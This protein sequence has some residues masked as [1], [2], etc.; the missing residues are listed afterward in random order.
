[1]VLCQSRL[2]EVSAWMKPSFLYENDINL[3]TCLCMMRFTCFHRDEPDLKEG[4][5]TLIEGSGTTAKAL[6]QISA[7]Y[8][9]YINMWA[10][11]KVFSN[12]PSL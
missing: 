7:G 9:I 2:G 5:D 6:I 8:S 4:N 3:K 11:S 1:M 12:W 10:S